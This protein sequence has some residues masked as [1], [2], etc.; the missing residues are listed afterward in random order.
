M[1]KRKNEKTKTNKK[2]IKFGLYIH[3]QFWFLGVQNNNLSN[4]SLF[5]ILFG[6][7]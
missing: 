4:D 2:P 3:I 1:Q 7:I 6:C 5:N